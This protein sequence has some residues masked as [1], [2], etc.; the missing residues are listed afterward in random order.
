MNIPLSST[1]GSIVANDLRA[2]T[3]LTRHG[4][5]FCCKGGRTV[6]EVCKTKSLDPDE[7]IREIGKALERDTSRPEDFA[8]WPLSR[9]ID[10]IEQVHHTYVSDRLVIVRQYLQKLC[11][12]H[13]ERHPELHDIAAEFEACCDTLTKHMKKEELVLFPHIKRLEAAQLGNSAPPKAYFGTIV[14]P[15][16]MMEHEHDAEGERFRRISELS[17]GYAV[18]ED[19]CTT[20]AAAMNLLKEFEQDL[21][22][23]IHLENNILFPRALHME[24][25]ARS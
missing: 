16:R 23:H 7:L 2:A 4:I 19:G 14:N 12:V 17:F 21:H 3:V 11:R 24:E 10:H 13:G 9:L 20:Y 6:Q 22:I 15:V 1:V 18:P 5:D 25:A 8:Q